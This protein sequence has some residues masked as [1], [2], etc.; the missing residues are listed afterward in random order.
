M[1]PLFLCRYGGVDGECVVTKKTGVHSQ[2]EVP[3]PESRLETTPDTA[4]DDLVK[5]VL[6]LAETVRQLMERQAIRRVESGTLSDEEIERLGL[7]LLRLEERMTEL[8]SQF[9]LDE[10]DLSLRLG[11][12]R[13]LLNDG[14]DAG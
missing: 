12:V 2:A 7:T 13:D 11:T 8:R 5:L 14:G 10:A 1:G 3:M 9:K 6:A 4:A